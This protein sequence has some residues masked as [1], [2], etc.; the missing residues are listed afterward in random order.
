M[1][2]EKAIN[3]ST[4][5]DK[6]FINQSNNDPNCVRCKQ[7][8]TFNIMLTDPTTSIGLVITIRSDSKVR[9]FNETIYIDRT[10]FVISESRK[11]D[12][13]T[14]LVPKMPRKII[15]I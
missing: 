14:D 4:D 8:Y 2:L 1:L 13:L 6:S 3:E 9:R 11:T 15:C 10:S 7:H 5:F 12:L